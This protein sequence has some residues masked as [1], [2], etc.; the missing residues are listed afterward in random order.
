MLYAKQ[1]CKQCLTVLT[2]EMSLLIVA[3]LMI[4]QN[5]KMYAWF[6][7]RS[8]KEVIVSAFKHHRTLHTCLRNEVSVNYVMIAKPTLITLEH[9]GN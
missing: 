3:P 8:L 6:Q 4:C 7:Q 2:V 9:W 1:T 5:F